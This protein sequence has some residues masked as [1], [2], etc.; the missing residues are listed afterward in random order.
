[1]G[2]CLTVCVHGRLSHGLYTWEIVSRFVYMGDCLTVCVH[3]RLSHGLYTWEIVSR[4]VYM[5]DCLTV[6]VRPFWQEVEHFQ[7]VP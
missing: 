7:Y 5:G 4:F 3:G 1:M 6:C 2:D